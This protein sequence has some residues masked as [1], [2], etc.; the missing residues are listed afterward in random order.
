MSWYVRVSGDFNVHLG[1]AGHPFRYI[2]VLE[3]DIFD[4]FEV[5]G[6]AFGR[7]LVRYIG[8]KIGESFNASLSV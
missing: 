5:W 2:F 1:W 6:F 3:Q 4:F 7:G 8:R